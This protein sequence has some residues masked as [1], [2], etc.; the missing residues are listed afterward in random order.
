MAGSPANDTS[1]S[2]TDVLHKLTSAAGTAPDGTSPPPTV[3]TLSDHAIR[4][5]SPRRA[6]P[7][8]DGV[9]LGQ[10]APLVNDA[11]QHAEEIQIE[12][13]PAWARQ[14]GRAAVLA[15]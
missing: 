1:G 9:R 13:G 3:R 12:A 7:R 6:P 14:P 10:L 2:A 8:D 15:D 4:A 5:S 11:G